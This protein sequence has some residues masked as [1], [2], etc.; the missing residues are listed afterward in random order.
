MSATIAKLNFFAIDEEIFPVA[1]GGVTP[2]NSVQRS[3][4]ISSGGFAYLA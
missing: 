3:V 4:A 1:I 2:N